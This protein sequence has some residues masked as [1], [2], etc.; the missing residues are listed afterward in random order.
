MKINASVTGLRELGEALSRLEEEIKTKILRDAGKKA[1]E[2]VL[3]DMKSNAGFDESS[4]ASH[5]R[6]SIKIRSTKS[7]KLNSSVLITVGPS[8]KHFIK[9]FAQEM[10]TVK[11]V[12][13]PFIRPAL[14]YNKHAVLKIL[15]TEI[16]DAL[17]RF[18]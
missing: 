2:P 3:D 18:K 14:D 12:S 6:D 1:M 11:Q 8:N 4:Q 7:K 17:Y 9:A 13:R 10:G 16:R 5:M 15:T